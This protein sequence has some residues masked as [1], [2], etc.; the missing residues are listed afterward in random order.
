M[1]GIAFG[2]T[3]TPEPVDALIAYA[4]F[5]ERVRCEVD[6][7]GHVT[8]DELRAVLAQ[9]DRDLGRTT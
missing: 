5:E 3:P 8:K 9:L 1:A 7:P 2:V 6:E 4:R